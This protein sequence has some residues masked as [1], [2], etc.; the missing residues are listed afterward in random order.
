MSNKLFPIIPR[1]GDLFKVFGFNQPGDIDNL[2]SFFDTVQNR[3]SY[4]F[5]ELRDKS[6]TPRANVSQTD[7]G[8]RIELAAPGFSRSD[9]N[10]QVDESILTISTKDEEGAKDEDE[11]YTSCECTQSSFSRSWTLP[12][13]V[14]VNSITARYDAGIL[15][16][17][18]PS[19]EKDSETLI[20]NVD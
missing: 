15:S 3:T 1:R 9:F 12:K 4:N 16:L 8:F 17:D 18:I 7:G 10:I 19:T 6:S 2:F 11:D 5:T 14:N 13:R 20:I